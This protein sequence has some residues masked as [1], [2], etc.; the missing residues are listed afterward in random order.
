[1]PPNP[2]DHARKLAIEAVREADRAEVRASR[3]VRMEGFGGPAQPSLC[4]CLTADTQM[5][6]RGSEPFPRGR[7]VF[8]RTG[9]FQCW[10]RPRWAHPPVT[11]RVSEL[12]RPQCNCPCAGAVSLISAF[13]PSKFWPTVTMRLPISGGHW[14]WCWSPWLSRLSAS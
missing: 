4:Q 5:K 12:E 3:S 6:P 13:G 1:M 10:G 7:L 8:T 14:R 9:I 11:H 2:A